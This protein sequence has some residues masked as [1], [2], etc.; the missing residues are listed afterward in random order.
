MMK[1]LIIG[2]AGIGLG[3]VAGMLLYR[4]AYTDSGK[5]L[6][7]DVARMIRDAN[8]YTDDML[9]QTRQQVN[10]MRHKMVEN[11]TQQAH[12]IADRA[13][14]VKRQLDAVNAD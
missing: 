7:E 4:Y 11:V 8:K 10:E 2:L 9:M 14:R 5:N 1:N 12:T 13:D 3:V 6:R